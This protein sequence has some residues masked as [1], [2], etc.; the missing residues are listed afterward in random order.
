MP[1]VCQH[2]N[3]IIQTARAQRLFGSRRRSSQVETRWTPSEKNKKIKIHAF[4]NYNIPLFFLHGVER[5]TRK[6]QFVKESYNK[7][8]GSQAL[9]A[10]VKKKNT[11]Y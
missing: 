8:A 4:I 5:P 9:C 1:V 7:S 6:V 2:K 10:T 11:R 3:I